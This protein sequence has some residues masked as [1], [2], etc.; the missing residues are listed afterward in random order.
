KRRH[1]VPEGRR[2]PLTRK[3]L[4]QP[5]V[6]LIKLARFASEAHARGVD[7]A[8]IAAHHINEP[9]I[10]LIENV[11]LVHSNC[12]PSLLEIALVVLVDPLQKPKHFVPLLLG[13]LSLIMQSVNGLNESDVQPVK[14]ALSRAWHS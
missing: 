8:E 11:D 13:D 4:D 7:D 2:V 9:H 6:A 12:L 1:C 5:L 3:E 10:A 14:I